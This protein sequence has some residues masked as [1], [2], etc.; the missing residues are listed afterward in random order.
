MLRGL[1]ERSVQQGRFDS[2][3]ELLGELA[4][5]RDHFTGPEDLAA[6]VD[7]VELASGP[8]EIRLI[9]VAGT[10]PVAGPHEF[11]RLAAAFEG[12]MPVSALPQ[13][14]YEPGE[15]LPASLAA[16]LG[17]QADAVLKSADGPFVLVG[18]SAGALMAHALGAELADRGR[19]PHGIVLIDVYPP[20]RQQAVQ[21]WLAELTDTMFGREG[22]RVDDTRLTALGA[23]HR[24]TSTWQPRDLA[25]PTLLVRACEPLGE[26]PDG[27]SWQSTWPFPH[28]CVDVPG[29]HF[30]MVQE[31]A[32]AVAERIRT[33]TGNEA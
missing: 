23:Y 30:S 18:H 5:H 21:G 11:L 25:V 15:Q 9:C 10:A 22:V 33:W 12:S 28:T 8:G 7:L 19:P 3:L 17:V 26:W 2:Y 13:P 14:G 4:G 27:T 31:H 16:V 1:Y 6:S 32:G 24:F 29:N 20:G